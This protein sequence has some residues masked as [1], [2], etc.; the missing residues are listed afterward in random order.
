M[1]DK[2]ILVW[3]SGAIG[4][5]IGA[6]LA[7]AGREVVFVDIAKDH[8]EQIDA[9]RLRIDG[10]GIDFTTGGRTATPDTVEGAYNLILLAVKIQDAER[11][12]HA[13]QPH[14]A[15]DGRVVSCQ[16][17]LASRVVARIIGRERTLAAAMFLPADCI[18]PGH[19]TYSGR[20]SFYIGELDGRL[21]ES[22]HQTVAVFRDFDAGVKA[23]D[24]IFGNIWGKM[25]LGVLFGVS[26]LTNET[27]VEFFSRPDRIPLIGGL[28]REVLRV[29]AADG[30]TAHDSDWFRSDAFLSNDDDAVRQSIARLVEVSRNSPKT[31]SGYWRDLTVH[32]RP[33][34]LPAQFM[35]MVAIA[36]KHGITVPLT[37]HFLA[38]IGDVEEGRKEIGIPLIQELMASAA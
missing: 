4:G 19:I 9:G 14:L 5:T 13:L 7:R 6:Y 26:A 20:T 28:V 27:R 3:G 38:L 12:A 25:A 18:A 22:L 21:T 31:H 23:S 32:K 8:L 11:A 30:Y 2:R 33:T 1:S 16:N 10:P 24:D 35:P 17:G 37:K 36:E 34:E 15:S 29:A